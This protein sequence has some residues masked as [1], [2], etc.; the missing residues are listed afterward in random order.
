MRRRDF[1]K[2]AAG[3]LAAAFFGRSVL[4]PPA[5]DQV[6]D[7]EP[8]AWASLYGSLE[9]VPSLMGREHARRE[10]E[11]IWRLCEVSAVPDPI[12]PRARI[13]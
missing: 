5:E 1:L 4:A 11:I 8:D 12:D 6:L 2:R 9:D 7:E 3:T 13:R 10:A